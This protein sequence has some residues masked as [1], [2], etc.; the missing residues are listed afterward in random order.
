MQQRLPSLRSAKMSTVAESL[1]EK[2]SNGACSRVNLLRTLVKDTCIAA[3]WFHWLTAAGVI[4]CVG[5]CW[6]LSI[7][8]ERVRTL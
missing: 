4:T 3:V 2:Y 7:V 5:K 8:L 6:V 1:P